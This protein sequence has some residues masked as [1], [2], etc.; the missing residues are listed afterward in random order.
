MSDFNQK[1]NNTQI[2]S[3]QV[4]KKWAVVGGEGRFLSVHY[5]PQFNKVIID[6][7]TTT[8]N[9]ALKENVKCYINASQFIAYLKAD[10]ENRLTHLYPNFFGEQGG[11]RVWFG[12]SGSPPIA[13]VFKISPWPNDEHGRSFKCG[14]FEG[15]KQSTGAVKPIYNKK[16]KEES[17]KVTMAELAEMLE[18]LQLVMMAAKITNEVEDLVYED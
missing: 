16:L 14:W 8:S 2:Q 6:I 7:G 18:N 5:W 15:E 11:G 1:A 3:T 4:Y 17:I 12:G 10:V 13:R 9:N